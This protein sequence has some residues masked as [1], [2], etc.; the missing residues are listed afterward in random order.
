MEAAPGARAHEGLCATKTVPDEK[1][2][3]VLRS[4]VDMSNENEGLLSQGGRDDGL[5]VDCDSCTVRGD[6][7]ADCVVTFLIGP[8]PELRWQDDETR[9]V[10]VLAD[11]GLVP[12]LRLVQAPESGADDSRS[13]MARSGLRKGAD[14]T[15]PGERRN[16]PA[17]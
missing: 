7:C 14:G 1:L 12:P 10:A 13:P 2:S 16:R 17:M 8:P 4:V 15:N 9:A 6:A 5:V 11:A 3:V